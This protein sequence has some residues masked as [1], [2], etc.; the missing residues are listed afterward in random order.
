MIFFH[1]RKKNSPPYQI[2]LAEK[3]EEKAKYY[4]QKYEEK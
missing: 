1:L 2:D 4:F 3:M